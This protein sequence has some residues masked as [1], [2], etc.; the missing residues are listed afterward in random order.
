MKNLFG[1]LI[2]SISI[3][4]CTSKAVIVSSEPD[5]DIYVNNT[6]RGKGNSGTVEIKKKSCVMVSVKKEGFLTNEFNY[7]PVKHYFQAEQK[8]VKINVDDSYVASARNDYANKD[9]E[10]TINSKFSEIEAWKIISQIVTSYFDNLEMA[11]KETGY[12]KTAWQVKNF[13]NKTIRT[14]V[15]VRQ[16]DS[17]PLKY[18]IKIVSEYSE[19]PNTNVRSDEMFKEWDRVLKSYEGLITEF[20]S[21]LGDK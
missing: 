15:I 5:A 12:L 2:F 14:R 4:S 16:T 19:K 1:L 10:Q 7:C 3:I 8:Y 18:K 21:R 13:S 11:D 20:Q 6:H 9:F 17:E